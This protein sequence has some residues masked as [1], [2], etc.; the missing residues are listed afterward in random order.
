M[1]PFFE[2][3]KEAAGP[4]WVRTGAVIGSVAYT[5]AYGGES[6]A[7]AHGLSI[8]PTTPKI[9]FTVLALTGLLVFWFW[10]YANNLRLAATPKI[11]VFL[12]PVNLG[13]LVVPTVITTGPIG[14]TGATGTIGVTSQRGPSSKWIQICVSGATDAPLEQCA[15]RLVGFDRIN[16]DGSTTPLEPE[17]IYLKW[18]MREN[19]REI[20]IPPLISE[21]V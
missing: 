14:A 1:P 17:H 18:S 12:N 2:T 13:I 7:E 19:E 11:R 21:A 4:H 3:F 16:D 20:T 6:I 9:I 10:K 8:L 15:A 5:V